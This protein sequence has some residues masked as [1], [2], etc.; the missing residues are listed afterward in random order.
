[1]GIAKN[2]RQN[3]VWTLPSLVRSDF[4]TTAHNNITCDNKQVYKG[5]HLLPQ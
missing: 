2:V 3:S 4:H 5:Q 1:V